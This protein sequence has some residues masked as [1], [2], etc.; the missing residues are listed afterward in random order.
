MSG[1]ARGLRAVLGALAVAAL[2][3]CAA[4]PA[5]DAA[6]STSAAAP[7]RTPPILQEFDIGGDFVLAAHD[8]TAFDLAAHR[9]E[10]FL[11]FFGYTH[12]PDFC[13][14]TLSLLGQVYELLGDDGSAVTTLFVTIDPERDTPA[15]MGEYLEYFSVPAL[16]LTGADDELAP[17]LQ[18]YA[19]IMEMQTDSDGT[20]LFG[21]TTHIYLIDHNGDV[22]Y[23]FRPDDAPR[24][25]AAGVLDQI[26][27]S[28]AAQ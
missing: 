10:V 23:T 18:S 5:N 8:G 19:G 6:P 17:I 13:P 3:S 12:C 25:I 28:R 16:G 22:R 7:I 26:N 9:G 15:A 24:F 20:V 1:R 11:L 4:E 2:A 27:V 14:A 21:H